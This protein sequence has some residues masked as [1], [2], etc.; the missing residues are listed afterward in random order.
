MFIFCGVV[1]GGGVVIGDKATIPMPIS[2]T[3]Y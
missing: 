2:H 1:G 3:H